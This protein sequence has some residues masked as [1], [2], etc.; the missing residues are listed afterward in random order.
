MF[1]PIRMLVPMSFVVTG[2]TYGTLL[3]NADL[4]GDGSWRLSFSPTKFPSINS[5]LYVYAHSSVTNLL[6]SATVNFDIVG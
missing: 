4:A 3:G 6:G 1:V 2:T 5:N